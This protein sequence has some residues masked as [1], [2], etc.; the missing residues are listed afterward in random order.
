MQLKDTRTTNGSSSCPTLLHYIAKVLLAADPLLITFIEDM[1]H[2]EAAARGNSV[3]CLALA[4]EFNS[5]PVSFPEIVASVQSLPLG[6][7]QV[8]DEIKYLRD[9]PTDAHDHFILVMEV[10][11]YFAEKFARIDC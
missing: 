5:C 6:L 4:I 8:K 2:L 9:T 3:D 11:S 7:A 1:P 10:S